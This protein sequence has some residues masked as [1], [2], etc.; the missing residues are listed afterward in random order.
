[1]LNIHLDEP[2]GHSYRLPPRPNLIRIV[3]D[4]HN[5]TFPEERRRMRFLT[6]LLFD[7]YRLRAAYAAL[8]GA[9]PPGASSAAAGLRRV[10]RRQLGP[11]AF[12]L[13]P[14]SLTRTPSAN[15]I[16]SLASRRIS[17]ERFKLRGA[18]PGPEESPPHKG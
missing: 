7:H 10:G 11:E 17:H 3:F 12:L 4:T 14:G 2:E 13:R 16:L 9:A 5:Y 8:R 15:V 1:L 18:A 6:H